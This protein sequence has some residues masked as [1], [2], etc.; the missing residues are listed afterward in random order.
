M[1]TLHTSITKLTDYLKLIGII[2][3]LASPALV[4]WMVTK[5]EFAQ[6]E[7]RILELERFKEQT[8]RWKEKYDE[9]LNKKLDSITSDMK[10]MRTSIVRLETLANKKESR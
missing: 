1:S 9:M 8:E 6:K 10:D 5:V 3:G 2:V 4:F 7:I